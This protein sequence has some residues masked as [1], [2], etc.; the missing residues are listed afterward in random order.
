MVPNY[1]IITYLIYLP[2]ILFITIK[3]GWMFYKNGEIF[4]LSIFEEQ[5][6]V[7]TVNKILLMGYYL[8]NIGYSLAVISFWTKVDSITTMIESL[9]FVIGAIIIF[10]AILHYNNIIILKQI[11]KRKLL[12]T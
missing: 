8:V 10:L 2:I 5:N 4:L 1:N 11:S 3:V 7:K 6:T 9:S 12:N